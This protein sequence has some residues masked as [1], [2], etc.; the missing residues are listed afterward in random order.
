MA[1]GC[2][3]PPVYQLHNLSKKRAPF[4]KSERCCG[5]VKMEEGP[6][7]ISCLL[8]KRRRST[9]Q[10]TCPFLK[11]ESRVPSPQM[12]SF[13]CQKE[14]ILMLEAPKTPQ[15]ASSYCGSKGA[16]FLA[17]PV[18]LSLHCAA[19][20]AKTQL[21]LRP[22]LFTGDKNLH[23]VISLGPLK[24]TENSKNA[25]DYCHC[26][27]LDLGAGYCRSSIYLCLQ[28]VRF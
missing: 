1:S 21:S 18:P 20:L 8:T 25:R 6:A 7:Q 24:D 2:L 10:I 15:S 26:L 19:T 22:V 14:R 9:S 16:R 27:L 23:V 13:Y 5:Q 11:S 12:R 4:T 3:R 28:F 17:R